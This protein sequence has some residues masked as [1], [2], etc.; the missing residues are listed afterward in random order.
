MSVQDI[1]CPDIGNFK[2]VLVID[3]LVKPGDVIALEA[4]IITLETDKATMDVPASAA[5]RVV[6]VLVARGGKVSQGTLLARVEGTA[7]VAT[8]TPPVAAAASAGVPR[9]AAA[10]GP[11]PAA[12]RE[13]PGPPE[14]TARLQKVSVNRHLAQPV[15]GLGHALH[16]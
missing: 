4:P 1:A 15:E 11:E 12:D 5:G 3:V 8:A 2:D 13:V 16:R 6:E 7:A 9:P 14:G 10:S